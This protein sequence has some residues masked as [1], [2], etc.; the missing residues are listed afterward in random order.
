M[1]AEWAESTGTA[2]AGR[3]PASALSLLLTHHNVCMAHMLHRQ[4][5]RLCPRRRL[6]LRAAHAQQ[7]QRARPQN[8]AMQACGSSRWQG[9]H[10]M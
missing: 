6:Q 1:Q 2:N 4:P 9:R 3:H 5:K 8:A 10:C 7:P